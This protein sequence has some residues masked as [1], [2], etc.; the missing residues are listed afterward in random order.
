MSSAANL[1]RGGKQ[2]ALQPTRSYSF[3]GGPLAQNLGE[4]EVAILS[5]IQRGSSD[6]RGTGSRR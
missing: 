6:D 2:L 5:E 3:P 4:V 1:D